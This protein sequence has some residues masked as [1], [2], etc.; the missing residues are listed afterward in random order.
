MKL[1][2]ENLSL[3]DK[4]ELR[5]Y[6]SGMINSARRKG[7]SPFRCTFLMGEMATALGWLSVPRESRESRHVWARAIIIHQM[8]MEGYT[9][10][11]IGRQMRKSHCTV[12]YLRNK[13]ADVFAYPQMY[14]DVLDMWNKFKKQIDY[15]IQ[16]RTNSDPVQMGGVLPDCG[17][18]EMGK[19]SG[20]VCPPVNI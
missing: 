9:V 12:T 16:R 15:D 8:C 7:H 11:E 1:A 3:K 18:S 10:T 17:K 20:E 13:M 5:E 6:L 14:G 2:V 4:V 19:E